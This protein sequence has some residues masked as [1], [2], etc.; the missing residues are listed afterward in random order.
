M[1]AEQKQEI[2]F[3]LA[4]LADLETEIEAAKARTDHIRRQLLFANGLC[5]AAAVADSPTIQRQ[6]WKFDRN[7][8]WFED[9]LPY[10]GEQFFRQ[11]LRVSPTTFWYI[12]EMCGP[13]LRREDTVMRQAISVEKRVAVSLYKLCSSAEDRS[14]AHLFGIG[15]STVNTLY[16]E[17][18]EAV[19]TTL[20][21]EWVKMP[22]A[23]TMADH[24]KEC[25]AVCDFPQAVGALDGC[26][27]LISP[28]KQSATDYYNYKGWHSIVLL[29]L[30]DHRYRFPYINVGS[31]GRCHDT[32]VYQRSSLAQCV[33]GPLFQ[34]PV[35]TINGVAVP[36][37]ILCDQAFP[38]TAHLVKPFSHRARLDDDMRRFYYHLSKARRIVENAFG[39]MKARFKYTMKRLEC[40][41]DNAPLAIRTCCV[42]NNTCEVFSDPL[43]QQWASDSEVAS[44]V[45]QQP[46]GA[47]D[48][49]SASGTCVR[50]AIVGYYKQR[51]HQ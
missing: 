39:R 32:Y 18:C 49:R 33:E 48:T 24:I 4:A 25:S 7:E 12:V 2:A 10:L 35:A 11:S 13:L 36:P 14:I 27:F 15:R 6:R 29:A 23:E 42:V 46:N 1:C 28:P 22:S 50:D 20:E 40:D 41:L 43:M 47:A 26:H 45:Y 9:T 8:R 17:F 3:M 51:E 34:A 16:R 21:P 5:V 44:S 37:L 31:P 19:I 30:V 38:V